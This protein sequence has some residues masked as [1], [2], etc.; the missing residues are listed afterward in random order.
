M[1]ETTLPA[2]ERELRRALAELRRQDV[3]RA[4]LTPPVLELRDAHDGGDAADTYTFEGFASVTGQPYTLYKGRTWVWEEVVAPGAFEA[5]LGRDDLD[6]V[7]NWDH[8]NVY[9]MARTG[10]SGPGQLDLSEV[11]SGTTTGLRAWARLPKDDLD[12]Q[13]LAPKLRR[14]LVNQMSF[15]F[16][17]GSMRTETRI[18][19]DVEIETDIIESVSELYDVCVCA[20]GANPHTSGELRSVYAGLR[21]AGIDPAAAAPRPRRASNDLAAEATTTSTATSLTLAVDAGRAAPDPVAP[22]RAKAKAALALVNLTQ[23]ELTR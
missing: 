23:K 1:D 14:G 12:V 22:L 8:D 20:Q 18:E 13:R 5:V 7:L 10:V 2:D 21:R 17:I 11:T 3:R 19:D 4:R 15:K 6:V 9:T 16:R